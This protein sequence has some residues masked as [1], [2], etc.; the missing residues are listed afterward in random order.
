MDEDEESAHLHFFLLPDRYS[1]RTPAVN[2]ARPS[3][4]EGSLGE[5]DQYSRI[6]VGAADI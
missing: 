6:V 1:P 4:R 2:E 3:R 5:N